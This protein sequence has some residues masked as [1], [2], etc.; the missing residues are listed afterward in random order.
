MFKV[1]SVQFGKNFDIL[2]AASLAKGL[3]KGA[4]KRWGAKIAK[5]QEPQKY[6]MIE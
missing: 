6:K 4:T 3:A 2:E 1:F 5:G